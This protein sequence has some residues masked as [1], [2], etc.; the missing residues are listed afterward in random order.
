MNCLLIKKNCDLV[1]KKLDNELY[2][3]CGF[4][5]SDNFGLRFTWHYNNYFITLYSK[6]LGNAGNENKYDLPPPLDNKLFFGNIII[7][8][9]KNKNPNNKNILNFT[10]DDWNKFYNHAFG[11]FEDINDTSEEE[12]EEEEILLKYLTNT[13]YSKESGFIVGD[14]EDIE[15][16]SDY[17]EEIMNDSDYYIS[18]SEDED[19]EDEEEDEDEEDEDEDEEDEEDEDEE[20]EDEEEDEEEEEDEKED[21]N[22]EDDE[23]EEDENEEDDEEEEE[24]E[25]EELK[26]KES[27][28]I[29]N[30]ID[31]IINEI[32]DNNKS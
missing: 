20:D 28:D 14:N 17:S 1:H 15:L 12:E 21:E 19:E 31:I 30:N 6:S 2:Y 9:H 29:S 26:K 27:I 32:I 22:E 8:A 23:E 11:G 7:I 16:L 5:N 13:G 10:I 18:D 24:D 25:K 4:K 3:L